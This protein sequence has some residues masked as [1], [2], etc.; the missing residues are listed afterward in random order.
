VSLKEGKNRLIVNAT[1]SAGNTTI[2]ES[3]EILV[4]RKP[5]TLDVDAEGLWR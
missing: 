5:P 2:R 1:D 4:D 3:P